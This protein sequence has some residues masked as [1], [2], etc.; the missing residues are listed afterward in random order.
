MRPRVGMRLRDDLL[1]RTVQWV[2]PTRVQVKSE[3]T[4]SDG[5]AASHTW[6]MPMRRWNEWVEEKK[7]QPA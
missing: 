2:S 3:W 1:T 6:L 4:L 5:R 7:P